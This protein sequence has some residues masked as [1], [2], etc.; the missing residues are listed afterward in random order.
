MRKSAAWINGLLVETEDSY[1]RENPGTLEPLEKVFLCSKKEVENACKSAH[2]AFE[3]WSNTPGNIRGNILFKIAEKIRQRSDDL[4]VINS[5]ETGKPIKESKLV[6][7]AG[8][9][10]TFEYYAGMASKIH[11]QSQTITPELLSLTLKE[12][13]GVI[14]MILPWNFPLLLVSWKMAPALAAGCTM[15]IKPSELTPHGTIELAQI[16]EECGIPK[17][18]INV[19]PGK[20]EEAGSELIK[21]ELI[22]KISFT[23]S[24]LVGK[25][26]VEVTSKNLPK[27]SLELGGKAPNI[28]FE[29]AEIDS[30]IEANL[31]GGFFNQGENCTA[32]TRLL[33][34]DKIYN[35]FK[36]TFLQK[37]SAIKQGYPL[38][39][40]TEIG[41]LI[42]EDHLKKVEKLVEQGL[43]QGG[44]LLVGGKKNP[45]LVGHFFL[46]TVIEIDP[47]ENNV[48]FTE[49]VFGPVV[50]IMPFSKEEEAI[51]L[52]NQTNYG[53]AG[54]IW[55]KDI[56]RAIRV[57]KKINAG[58]LWINTYGG[59]IPETPYG[60]FK[61][62]GS[63]KELGLE[64]IEEFFKLKNISIFIGDSL[65][66]WYGNK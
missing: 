59:I 3:L 39:Q 17:G 54:G 61:Q 30:C 49:E 16:C 46:P 41:A 32:V 15:V 11:G 44:K 1:I 35:K 64:G 18:V 45:S 38:E 26:I 55:T 5:E 14:G 53:L 37:I 7:M 31:R 2:G 25:H 51:K 66:K 65:P 58:Y 4:A 47:S 33:V 27:L 12:P 50:A 52:A 6:E 8:V 23:G 43:Q 29:D 36:K 22:S 21:N 24:T 10:R 13:I 56:S 40:E 57:S 62:S 28:V 63:G 9:A 42:S 20:G 60:G 34:H 48:L 19:C